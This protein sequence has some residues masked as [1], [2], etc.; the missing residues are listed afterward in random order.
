VRNCRVSQLRCA[1]DYVDR[2][3]L[4]LAVAEGQHDVV[5][6]LLDKGADVNCEDRCGNTPLL[7]A[8]ETKNF[9]IAEMLILKGA[10][11]TRNHF[12]SVR[13]AVGSFSELCIVCQKAGADPNASDYNGRTALHLFCAAGNIRAVENLLAVGADVNVFDRFVQLLHSA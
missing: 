7:D 2:S 4:H 11:L 3:S 8:L 9:S 10:K 12:E 6:M 13:Q 1:G 5:K